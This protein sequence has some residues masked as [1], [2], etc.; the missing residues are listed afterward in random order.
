ML[1]Y[2][3]YLDEDKDRA[4]F[5]GSL[6]FENMSRVHLSMRSFAERM[7][8]RG[9]PYAIAGGM[10]L[11][12]HGYR[13]YSD[14]VDVLVTP[15]GLARIH[16]ELP[17]LGYEFDQRKKRSLRDPETG[18]RI[19]FLVT[20]E[21][22][23]FVERAPFPFPDPARVGVRIGTTVFVSFAALVEMK[24]GASL[25]RPDW[26]RHLVDVQEAI[27]HIKPSERVAGELHPSVRAMYLKASAMFLPIGPYDHQHPSD[28][29]S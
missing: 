29:P 8:E 16:S 11:Y 27:K 3:Q 2:E 1:T 22:P 7:D 15:E 26:L 23:G 9:I 13:R 17:A 20:G 10:A 4:F 6:H 12:V 14:D 5:E 19:D 28:L 24:L 25:M 21:F 18:V